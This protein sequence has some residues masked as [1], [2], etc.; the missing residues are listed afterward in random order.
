MNTYTHISVLRNEA[1]E[2]LEPAPNKIYID[3]T[4]GLGGHTEYLLQ[5][6]Q[7]KARILAFDKDREALD[8]AKKR[9]E[10][11]GNQVTYYHRSFSELARTLE[12]ENI[13]HVDGILLDAGISSMQLDN[14]Q[15][16]FSFQHEAPLDMRMDTEKGYPV[17]TVLARASFD[18]LTTI[19]RDYGEEPLAKK[20]ARAIVTYREK[21]PILQTSQLAQIVHDAYPRT[22]QRSARIHPATR[23]FQALRIYVN[24]E[25][26]ELQSLIEQSIPHL[27]SGARIAIISF[28]SLEDRIV[29]HSFKRYT[30][31]CICPPHI[32]RC[33]CNHSPELHILTK[34]PIIP[35]QQEI[36]TNPRSRSAKLRIAQK[37]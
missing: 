7:G 13:T 24:N 17:S 27:A 28:H 19:L 15:R 18:T 31:S 25:L 36:A 37:V 9:L 12:E 16:G 10:I 1:V 33:E 14:G 2:A 26:Q 20:I 23:T 32:M 3:C 30:I 8:I 5:L 6:T 34:K 11:Y 29:K 21:Q 35:T 4:L 22:W